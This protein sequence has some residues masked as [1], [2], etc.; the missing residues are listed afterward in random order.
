MDPHYFK[1][2]DPDP[3][4]REKSWIRKVKSGDLEVHNKAVRGRGRSQ[5][6]C[7]GSK[8][9]SGRSEDKRS[10]IRITRCR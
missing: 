6:K 5:W 3:H 4:L 2:L 7:G 1:K 9:S 10:L 8:W